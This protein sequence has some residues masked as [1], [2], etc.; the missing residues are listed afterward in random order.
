MFD[1]VVAFV[2]AH[3]PFLVFSLTAAIVVQI[4][5]GAVW[6]AKR[7]E[8]KGAKAGFFWWARKTIPLHPVIAGALFGLIPGL[9]LSP[10]VPETMAASSLYFAG[11]GLASTWIFALVKGVAKRKG[12]DLHIPGEPTPGSEG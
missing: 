6:T 2:A 1:D 11:S 7:A 4:F 8:G 10:D 3:W 9:P 5:K 12:V